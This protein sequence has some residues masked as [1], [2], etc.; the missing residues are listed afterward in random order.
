MAEETKDTTAS[1][2]ANLEDEQNE[3]D[4]DE[5]VS[6]SEPSLELDVEDKELFHQMME[7][8]VFYGSVVIKSSPGRIGK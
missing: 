3:E 1:V 6:Q 7:A 4:N 5:E 2:P 8:G